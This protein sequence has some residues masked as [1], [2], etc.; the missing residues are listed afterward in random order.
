M[1]HLIETKIKKANIKCTNNA[2]TEL[3]LSLLPRPR[4]NMSIEGDDTNAFVL[5]S[6]SVVKPEDGYHEQLNI[7]DHEN[8]NNNIDYSSLNNDEM[9]DQEN[10]MAKQYLSKYGGIRRHTIGTNPD[11]R[12]QNDIMTSMQYLV[13]LNKK[14]ILKTTTTTTGF[15][16]VLP[17]IKEI[18][19]NTEKLVNATYNNIIQNKVFN[20]KK[21]IQKSI[22][23]KSANNNNNNESQS[24]VDNNFFSNQ[25]LIPPVSYGKFVFCL[26]YNDNLNN[27]NDFY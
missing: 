9:D 23:E 18:N 2:E 8:E 25:Y 12:N 13:D 14:S 1:Y 3:V 19:N 22:F 24:K 4:K 26:L 11:N 21:Q 16:S 7:C 10:E 6:E 27:N 20:E 15:D 5:E 17:E